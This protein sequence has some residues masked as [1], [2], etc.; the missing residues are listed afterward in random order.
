MAATFTLI[1]SYT[2]GAG[3]ASSVTLG[4]GGT[5]PQTYTDLKVVYS[6]RNSNIYNEVHFR[7]NGSNANYSAKILSGNGSTASSF[8]GSSTEM[9]GA[10][11]IPSGNTAST[12]ANGEIYISNYTSSNNKSVS[13]DSVQENNGTTA[14]AQLTAGLWS[15]TNAINSIAFFP[16]TETGTL[17]QYSTFYLYGIKNS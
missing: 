16:A 3:G 10:M 5:I 11:S 6:C 17:V 2:V 1:D 12:F 7:F 15:N 4:S 8:N 14:I 13:I 9:Q